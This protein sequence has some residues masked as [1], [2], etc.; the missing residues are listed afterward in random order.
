MSSP[1]YESF[2]SWKLPCQWRGSLSNVCSC[3]HCLAVSP[4]LASSGTP[5]QWGENQNPAFY[6]QGLC[7]NHVAGFSPHYPN[8]FHLAMTSGFATGKNKPHKMSWKWW[9]VPSTWLSSFA[10]EKEVLQRNYFLLQTKGYRA[11]YNTWLWYLLW[12]MD[13]S[14]EFWDIFKSNRFLRQ[15]KSS[16][17][18]QCMS[19]SGTTICS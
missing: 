17:G 15:G 18:N 13:T 11:S 12:H 5:R 9:M 16:M 3:W 4:A 10:K 2:S 1:I 7:W 6:E 14:K 19:G 8:N